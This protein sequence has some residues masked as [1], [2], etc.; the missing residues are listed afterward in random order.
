MWHIA[1]A[2]F[3]ELIRNKILHTVFAFL[4]LLLGVSAL[5]GTVTIGDRIAVIKDFGLFA[6]SLAGCAVVVISGVSLLDKELKQKTIYNILS[7]PIS[8]AQFI[9]GKYLGLVLLV[10]VLLSL[11]GICI[12]LFTAGFEGNIDWRLFQ[13]VLLVILEDLI[14]ASVAIL[15]STVVVTT[16]LSGVFTFAIY[17]AGHSISAL[18]SFSNDAAPQ[19]E[20]LMKLAYYVLPDLSLYNQT[21]EIF[22]GS[23]L[24]AWYF[25]WV[26]FY[27]ICYATACIAISCLIFK[28]RDLT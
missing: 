7:K 9:V 23:G 20:S 1:V 19:Q 17:L 25:C 12:V 15:F 5:F 8:R 13:G 3:R 24:N 2:T 28:K 14:L 11:M 21:A 22:Y 16:A 4:S 26:S 18:L 27:A 10:A 6:L